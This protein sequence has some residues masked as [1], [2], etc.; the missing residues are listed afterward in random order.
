VALAF[1]ANEWPINHCID[2]FVQMCD[3][4]FTPRELHNI[5]ALHYAAKFNHGSTYKTRPLH[6]ALKN[7]LGEGLLF[8]G[9]REFERRYDVKVA[10]TSTDES[11]N[12][13]I[14]IS[15]YSRP[16]ESRANH[17]FRRPVHPFY[18]LTVW[19]AAAATSAAP[20]FFKPFTHE[21]TSRSYLDGAIYH[22]N[23]IRALNRERKYVWPD[24]AE[25]HPDLLL[26]IGTGR[27]SIIET[28]VQKIQKSGSTR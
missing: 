24:V 10:V 18:E 1:G 3:K 28:E 4:A 12:K 21:R 13:A 6:L 5:P 11:G 14:I 19:E 22:N 2:E 7:S 8:G 26:S 15:N 17:E 16:G 20:P 25:H 23:P 9:E 27:D